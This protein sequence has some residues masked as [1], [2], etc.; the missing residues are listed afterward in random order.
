MSHLSD[1][2]IRKTFFQPTE[3]T[4]EHEANLYRLFKNTTPV[5]PRNGLDDRMDAWVAG[6]EKRMSK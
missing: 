5:E 1:D 6:Y 2:D 4:P 3:M